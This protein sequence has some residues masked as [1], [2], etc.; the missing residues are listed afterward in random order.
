MNKFR[1]IEEYKIN[2]QNQLYFY[3]LAM[4]NPKLKSRK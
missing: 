3:F 1:K 2:I 4:N